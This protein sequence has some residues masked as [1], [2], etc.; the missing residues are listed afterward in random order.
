MAQFKLN[1]INVKITCRQMGGTR[2]TLI[3]QTGSQMAVYANDFETLGM[4][5]YSDASPSI[6]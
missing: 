5:E 4:T 6:S 1:S 2:S 3:V